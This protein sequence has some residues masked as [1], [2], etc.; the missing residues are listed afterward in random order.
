MIQSV[1]IKNFESHKDTFVEFDKG[2]NVLAG[3]SSSGKSAIR[4]ALQFV[5]Y[6]EFGKN[7]ISWWAV[8]AK[9]A[10]KEPTEV[11]IVLD[12]GTV[13][14]RRRS[15]TENVYVINDKVLE[16]VGSNV[17]EEVA[18]ALNFM[19][20]NCQSQMERPFLVSESAG[21]VARMFNRVV[22][23]EDADLYQ[24]AVEGMRR[25]CNTDLEATGTAITTLT[26]DI[27][28]IDWLDKADKV[29]RTIQ[30]LE[31]ATVDAEQVV[32]NL[33]STATQYNN[34]TERMDQTAC[35]E[36]ATYLLQAV[37]D[38][39]KFDKARVEQQCSTLEATLASMEYHSSILATWLAVEP[40]E[41][42]IARIT[43]ILE[44]TTLSKDAVDVLVDT[45]EA[46]NSRT[47]LLAEVEEELALV[48]TEFGRVEFC[49]LCHSRVH[50]NTVSL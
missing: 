37:E 49:P 19:D 30:R 14:T 36:R 41:R 24:S 21:E 39:N 1:Q 10:Q 33:S 42:F 28:S 45:M 40:A 2:M 5:I 31:D 26:A 17:P 13:I 8:N 44:S 23:L 27:N 6:N 38:I 20:I 16:A 18:T 34:A 46:H 50:E 7:Q 35:L 3:S 48:E 9:G 32:S 43:G 25:K 4:R 47:A 15:S 12:T 29:I 22:S 11:T